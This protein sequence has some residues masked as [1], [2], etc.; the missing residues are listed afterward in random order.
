MGEIV[1]G[2]AA[3]DRRTGLMDRLWIGEKY[4]RRVG[5][6]ARERFYIKVQCF[7]MK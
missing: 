2:L 6:D 7:L 4:S 5:L 3:W 1:T